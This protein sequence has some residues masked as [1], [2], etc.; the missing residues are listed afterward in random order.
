MLTVLLC[1]PPDCEAGR[2]RDAAQEP[3]PAHHDAAVTHLRRGRKWSPRR[4]TPLHLVH[5]GWLGTLSRGDTLP[6]GVH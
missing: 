4:P 1:L 3:G 6:G 2:V 5:P